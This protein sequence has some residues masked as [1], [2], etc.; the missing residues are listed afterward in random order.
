MKNIS[1]YLIGL[2]QEISDL[3]KPKILTEISRSKQIKKGEWKEGAW[4]GIYDDSSLIPKHNNNLG[5]EVLES[6]GWVPHDKI[7]P[8]K[9]V[10]SIHINR[11][12]DG[13]VILVSG[14]HEKGIKDHGY[15]GLFTIARLFSYSHKDRRSDVYGSTG[16]ALNIGLVSLNPEDKTNLRDDFMGVYW[17]PRDYETFKKICSEHILPHTL[18]YLNSVRSSKK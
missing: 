2:H 6:F 8:K 10:F 13:R 12:K 1:S 18:S 4:Y 5:I 14:V 9:G 11:P 16:L 7:S 3:L 15:G 17:G